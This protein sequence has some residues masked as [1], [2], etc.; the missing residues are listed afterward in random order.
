VAGAIINHSAFGLK[1]N[2]PLLL[3]FGLLHKAAVMED[4]QV[5]QTAANRHTPEKKKSAEKIKPPVLAEVG[6]IRHANPPLVVSH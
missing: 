4:L 2:G 3:V 6:T 1:G 5:D